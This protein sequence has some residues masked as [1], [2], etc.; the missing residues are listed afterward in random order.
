MAHVKGRLPKVLLNK[1]TVIT[2]A[3]LWS[4]PHDS[5]KEDICL[6]LGR[7]KKPTETINNESP[8]SLEPKSELT[9][10]DEEFRS[11]IE[12]LRENYEPF[13]QG[14]TAFIPLDRPFEKENAD[15]IRALFSHPAKH[16]LIQFTKINKA[17]RQCRQNFAML[18]APAESG[19]TTPNGLKHP[20][21]ALC[22]P[23]PPRH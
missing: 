4:I 23:M 5:G 22:L 18:N 12:F 10:N 19:Q 1:P 6:K 2:R 8:E 7:Y 17:R 21:T 14:V 9:L 11:L 15:Q 3:V 13:R 20:P 16:N